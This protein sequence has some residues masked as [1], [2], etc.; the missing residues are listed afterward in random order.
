MQDGHWFHFPF[1]FKTTWRLRHLTGRNFIFIQTYALRD[2]W[3][4]P[5]LFSPFEER[6]SNRTAA[7]MVKAMS[8]Y[9]RLCTVSKPKHNVNICAH[10]LNRLLNR[11]RLCLR[12]VSLR[13]CSALEIEVTIGDMRPNF[14]ILKEYTSDKSTRS[15]LRWPRERKV[16]LS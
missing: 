8:K 9:H 1:C 15:S 14:N 7:S 12:L 4:S 2:K 6:R 5:P 10:L 3:K 11:A 13:T 16:C